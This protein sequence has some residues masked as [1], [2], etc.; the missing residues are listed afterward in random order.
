MANAER[1]A[2]MGAAGFLGMSEKTLREVY[3]HHHP[4]HQT[5]A[6]NRISQR[7]NR[8]KNVSEKSE[9]TLE[10][11]SAQNPKSLKT[12]VGPGGLEPPTRPL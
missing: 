7:P 12:L 11:A 2:D 6:A 9:E 4:D 5:E 1:H 8:L 10:Q 3:D